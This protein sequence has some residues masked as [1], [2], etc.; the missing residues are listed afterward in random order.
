MTSGGKWPVW[1]LALLLYPVVVPAVA[2]NLFLLALM[3]Q[4]L[5]WPSLTPVQ[6]LLVAVPVGIPATFAAGSWLRRLLDEAE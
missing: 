2:I 5:D 3:A 4:V 6:A 1:R